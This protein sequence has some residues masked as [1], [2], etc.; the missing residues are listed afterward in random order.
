SPW[1]RTIRLDN[2][3]S[4]SLVGVN[5]VQKVD[6]RGSMFGFSRDHIRSRSAHRNKGAT[7]LFR[8]E[9]EESNIAWHR[10]IKIGRLPISI[11]HEETFALFK[12]SH[13]GR[14]VEAVHVLREVPVLAPARDILGGLHGTRGIERGTGLVVNPVC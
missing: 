14:V 4:G 10:L 2:D 8:G 9:E 7:S 1:R 3:L 11:E 6:H 12:A 5:P 13:H